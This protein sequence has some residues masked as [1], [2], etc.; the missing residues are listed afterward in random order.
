MVFENQRPQTGIEHMR[1]D[2]R[3]RD[4]RVSEE[5]LNGAE[6]SAVRQKMRGEGVSEGV[7]RDA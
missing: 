3:G 2:L 7:W 6:V 4:I 5:H 1:I